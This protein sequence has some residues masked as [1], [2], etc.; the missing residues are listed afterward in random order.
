MATDD[1]LAAPATQTAQDASPAPSPEPVDNSPEGSIR[2]KIDAALKAKSEP[3]QAQAEQPAAAPQETPPAENGEAVAEQAGEPD[4][5]EKPTIDPPAGW[6]AADKEWFKTLEPERQ[7]SI[8]RSYKGAQAAEAR[9][10]NEH[11]E[12]MQRLQTEA[13][14]AAQERQA[15]AHA[16]GQY[17]NPLKQ[18]FQ[19]RFADVLSGQIDVVSLSRMD[20]AR[21]SEFQ[22]YQEKFRQIEQTEQALSQRAQFEEQQNLQKFRETQ[23][24]RVRDLLPELKS[25]E[26]WRKFDADV[27][28]YALELGIAPDRIVRADADELT[29]LYKAMMWDRAKSAQS[30]P[31]PVTPPAPKPVPKVLKPSNGDAQS[32]VDDVYAAAR[33]K[34]RRTG[35]LEDVASAISAKMKRLSQR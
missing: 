30:A 23:N 33:N 22:A 4:T 17:A 31:R 10:A 29:V 32:R 20:P 3:A 13:Q 7:E 27:S 1:T 6:T 24:A 35:D 9:R 8:L 26:A 5:G 28:N 34:A 11:A 21:F 19:Q 2:R 14:Q 16:L 15:L 18:E 12:A 25:D